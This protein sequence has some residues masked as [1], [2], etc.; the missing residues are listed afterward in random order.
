MDRGA[1]RAIVHRVTKELDMTEH[2]HAHTHTHRYI[3]MYVHV[4]GVFKHIYA[5]SLDCVRVTAGWVKPGGGHAELACCFPQ[6]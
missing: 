3:Y 1:G 6:A 5:F 2:P 4:C